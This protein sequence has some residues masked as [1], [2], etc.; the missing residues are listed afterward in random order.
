M[1]LTLEAVDP[2]ELDIQLVAH[3][4]AKLAELLQ[5]DLDLDVV[6]AGDFV[7]AVRTRATN[8]EEREDYTV[9]R[10]FGEA[11]A[12]VMTDGDRIEIIV[13]AGLVAKG[14]D[15]AVAEETFLHEAY[16][17]LTSRRGESLNDLRIRH[18]LSL[19]TANGTFAAI[20]G[21]AAEEYR[22]ARTLAMREAGAATDYRSALDDGLQAFSDGLWEASDQRTLGGSVE[23]YCRS[24]MMAY[25]HL[26]VL[27]AYLAAHDADLD[28]SA[29]ELWEVWIAR[30]WP[31][32]RRVF[33][34]LPAADQEAPVAALDARAFALADLLRDLLAAIGFVLEDLDDGSL[35]FDVA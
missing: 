3:C 22:V 35:L 21:V 15:P 14:A 7:A 2:R 20:A 32:L 19:A 11:A 27:L 17:V 30:S 4:V 24:V 28:S 31:E 6:I 9:E 13:L 10:L 23:D 29:P 25:S 1:N 18:G 34:S 33:S 16:H 8:D 5:H 26:T 12:R